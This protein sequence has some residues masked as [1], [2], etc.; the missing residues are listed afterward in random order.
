MCI[1]LLG[2]AWC[3]FTLQLHASALYG[4]STGLCLTVQDQNT[5]SDGKLNRGL[6]ICNC[7]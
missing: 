3:S 4:E 1:T 6:A 2:N 5:K 7:K